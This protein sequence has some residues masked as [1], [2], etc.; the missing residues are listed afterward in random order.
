MLKAMHAAEPNF[1]ACK[2]VAKIYKVNETYAAVV[3]RVANAVAA[4]EFSLFAS[5]PL[6]RL[7]A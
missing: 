3:K 6:A 4:R 1:A 2:A 5:D 7:A